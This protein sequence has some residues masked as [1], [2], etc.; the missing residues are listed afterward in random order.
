ML[1]S[2]TVSKK[3]NDFLHSDVKITI[4]TLEDTISDLKFITDIYEMDK[5]AKDKILLK[6]EGLKYVK[7]KLEESSYFSTEKYYQENWYKE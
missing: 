5:E 2:A 6:I 1:E 3:H 4:S 7:F